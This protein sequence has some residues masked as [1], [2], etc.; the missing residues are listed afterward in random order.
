M[1]QVSLYLLPVSPSRNNLKQH[2]I[3][4]TPKKFKKVTTS[5]DL[6]KVSAPNPDCIP[7]VVLKN[8]VPKRSNMLAELF[9]MCLIQSCFP[10]CWKVTLVVPVFKNVVSLPSAVSNVFVLISSMVLGLLDQLQIF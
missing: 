7:V 2:N 1:T 10:D 3:F 6:S 9:N 5:L 4:V 8:C